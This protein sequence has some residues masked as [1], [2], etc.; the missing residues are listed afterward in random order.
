MRKV[1]PF[2]FLIFIASGCQQGERVLLEPKVDVEADIQAIKDIVKEYEGAVNTADIDRYLQLYA[3]DVIDIYP[4]KPA[5]SGKEAIRKR[6]QQLFEEV[7]LQDVYTVQNVKVSG[8]LAVAHVTLSAVITI[9][10]SG[11][12]FKTNGNWILVFRKQSSDSWKIIYSIWSDE[13]LISPLVADPLIGT[14]VLNST[15]SKFP[16]NTEFAM[17][18]QTLVVRE[19]GDTIE[20]SFKGTLMDGSAQSSKYTRAKGGGEVTRQPPPSE[21][22]SFLDTVIGPGEWYVTVLENGKQVG[23]YHWVVSKDGKSI[24]E[25]SEG[26]NSDGRIA[27]YDK[28]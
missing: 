2:I 22:T 3:D 17:K 13:S 12:S 20:F 7:T 24:S 1:I 9:K 28:Q 18:E 23:V 27:V 26:T 8:D 14:W 16:P 10:A 15:K 19:L 11:E 21:G 6:D 5:L 25:T 4:N